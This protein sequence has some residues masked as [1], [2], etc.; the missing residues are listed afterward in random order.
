MKRTTTL[1]PQSAVAATTR[2]ARWATRAITSRHSTAMRT[3][4][5]VLLVASAAGWS[6]A[7]SAQTNAATE[8]PLTELEKSFWVCDHAATTGRIDS[9]TATTC[10]GLFEALKQR[11]FGG[12]VKAML[13][14]WRQHKEAEHLALARA[15]N[16][17]LARLA[18]TAPK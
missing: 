10:G 12:D 16:P 2:G 18:P 5:A 8:L 1:I 11:K 15:G 4:A 9:A 7:S 17:S 14:W 3:A 6:A 13:T